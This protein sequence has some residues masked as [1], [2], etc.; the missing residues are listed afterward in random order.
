M[1]K[2]WASTSVTLLLASMNL[3][4]QACCAEGSANAPR[5]RELGSR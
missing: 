1:L 5:L 2:S 4:R 3:M